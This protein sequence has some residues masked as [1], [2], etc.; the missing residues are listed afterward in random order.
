[1]NKI[2]LQISSTSYLFNNNKIWNDIK[3]KYNLKFNDYGKLSNNYKK[4]IDNEIEV[5]FFL[6]IDIIDYPTNKI[7]TE[8]IN[9]ITKLL[10]KKIKKNN[11]ILFF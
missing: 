9:N 7:N 3:K 11:N 6:L 1:M 4:K 5:I 10:E 2:S 8:I